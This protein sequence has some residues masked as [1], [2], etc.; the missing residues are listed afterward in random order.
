MRELYI[1]ADH[2][3]FEIKKQLKDFLNRSGYKVVDVGNY[4]YDS[5]DDYPIFTF[6][7]G[8]AVVET[9]SKGILV[10][11]TSQG[12]CIAANKVKGVR[13]ATVDTVKEAK[14]IREHNDAN[15]ICLSALYPIPDITRIIDIFISTK[16]STAT[17]HRRRVNKIIEFEGNRWK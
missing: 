3:G 17:R 7:V 12:M 15:V 13:A 8:K 11:G 6:E 5:K 14:L 9:N 16:F 2:N 10:C 4:V 1:G